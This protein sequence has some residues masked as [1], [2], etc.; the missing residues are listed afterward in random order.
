MSTGS[1]VS[2]KLD[3][4][5]STPVPELDDHRHPRRSA[6]WNDG[7]SPREVLQSAARRHSLDRSGLLQVNDALRDT[8]LRSRDFD[9]AIVDDDRSERAV[10]VVGS[11]RR[12]SARERRL[13]NRQARPQLQERIDR[14]RDSSS[15]GSTSPPNSVEAFADPRRRE[16]ANTLESRPQS[17]VE[18][19]NRRPSIASGRG[20]PSV[21]N[22]SRLKAGT[23][24]A[25]ENDADDD[26][27]DV[28]FPTYEEPG[29]TY[30]IDYE[31]LEEFV[32][33]S[34]QGL[35]PDQPPSGRKLGVSRD[36]SAPMVF[37]DLRRGTHKQ[38]IPQ[39]VM[40]CDSP[41]D[42]QPLQQF[43]SNDSTRKPANEQDEK[44]SLQ[45]L[46]RKKDRFTLFS[47][48]TESVTYGTELGDFISDGITTFRDLFELGP[49]GGVWWLDVT[50]PTSAELEC[51]R[52]AFKIH[53]LTKEDIEQQEAREKVELFS[54]Y[55]FVC[56]RS[57]HSD[58]VSDDFLQAVNVYIVVCDE[59][60]L[61]FSFSD[62]P[63]AANVRKRINKSRDFVNLGSDYICYALMYVH[64][65]PFMLQF[66]TIL[67]LSPATTLSILSPR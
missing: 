67:T 63:H 37:H 52:K 55:Y 53:P 28:G 24:L 40:N 46:F 16:R 33:L 4:R 62:T 22:A 34:A 48:A 21:S 64:N 29:K 25:E 20:R 66:S 32:A 57:F 41:Y 1:P 18:G 23:L 65:L 51:L 2:E 36:T 45:T 17:F 19:S 6:P 9:Q 43:S 15:S 38:D 59:G 44:A 31:E 47:S 26:D 13:T 60:V 35:I 56:F 14:S 39:I 50:N 42:Q 3:T 30:K 10:D 27:D 61:S 58:P 49:D 12:G 8:N 11:G 5:F 54:Q 7:E